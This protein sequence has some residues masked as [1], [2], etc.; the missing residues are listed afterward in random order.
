MVGTNLNPGGPWA[1]PKEEMVK[2]PGYGPNMEERR[3]KARQLLAEAGFPNGFSVEVITRSIRTFTDL[4]PFNLDQLDRVGIKAT[5]K[6][7]EQPVYV[8]A[9]YKGNFDIASNSTALGFDDPD[10]LFY[11]NFKCGELRNYSHS[12]DAEIERLGEQQ[13]ATLDLAQRKQILYQMDRKLIEQAIWPTLGWRNNYQV[14]WPEVRGFRAM[15]SVQ[16]AVR[17]DHVWLAQ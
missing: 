12:C 15:A 1:F 4:A 9:I 11:E 3:A 14:W 5:L 17:F 8:D 2:L 7:M 10:V 13:S 6:I 16:N